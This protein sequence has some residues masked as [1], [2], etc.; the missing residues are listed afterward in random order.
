MA[1]YP[2]LVLTRVL[3]TMA[4]LQKSETLSGRRDLQRS[5]QEQLPALMLPLCD[6]EARVA[7]GA[8]GLHVT[9]Q[10]NEEA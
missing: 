2:G 6:G 1:G 5:V 10:K 9:E 4:F 3:V 7:P 8:F